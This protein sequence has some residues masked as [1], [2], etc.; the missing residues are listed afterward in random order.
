[1]SL[2]QRIPE[3]EAPSELREAS[4]KG[5]EGSSEVAGYPRAAGRLTAPRAELVAEAL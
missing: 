5:T 3:L 2:T 4:E 1:M